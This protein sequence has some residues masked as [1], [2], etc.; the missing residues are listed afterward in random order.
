MVYFN[1]ASATAASIAASPTSNSV[2]SASPIPNQW[3]NAQRA[4]RHRS[5]DQRVAALAGYRGGSCSGAG[6]PGWWHRRGARL[7]IAAPAFHHSLALVGAA[8]ERVR[9]TKIAQL[10]R[11][12]HLLRRGS[13]QRGKRRHRERNG[14]GNIDAISLRLRL[15]GGDRADCRQMSGWHIMRVGVEERGKIAGETVDQAVPR[16][17]RQGQRRGG[18]ILVGGGDGRVLT[19]FGTQ[20][21]D[22]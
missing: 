22:E 3:P 19:N 5:P 7:L 10:Q 12:R 4:E 16:I 11:R 17:R 1:M 8:I 15:I 18:G 9:A 13:A 21:Y 2:I 20:K 14:T 6:S